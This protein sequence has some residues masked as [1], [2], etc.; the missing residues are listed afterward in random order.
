MRSSVRAS[1]PA[2]SAFRRMRARV[3]IA[4][5]HSPVRADCSRASQAAAVKVTGSWGR[6]VKPNT[7]I[8]HSRADDVVPFTDS[9]ELVKY[10]GSTWIEAGTDHRLADPEP[11]AAM[12]GECCR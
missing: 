5:G 10:S 2:V 4:A 1:G 11:L 8:L 9:E 12:Q 3:A 6:T 7:H